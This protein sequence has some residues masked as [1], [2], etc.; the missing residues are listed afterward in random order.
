MQVAFLQAVAFGVFLRL[1]NKVAFLVMKSIVIA[2]YLCASLS[3]ADLERPVPNGIL[4]P[5]VAYSDLPLQD[6]VHFVHH[7]ELVIDYAVILD[8]QELP[9][10]ESLGDQENQ[11]GVV[12]VIKVTLLL[13]ANGTVE[14]PAEL[15][16]NIEPQ[17]F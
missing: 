6:E 4:L 11:L 14:E 12:V 2:Y 17:V 16:Q 13:V 15:F 1:V 9:R 7:V 5:S 3:L 8:S 10:Q